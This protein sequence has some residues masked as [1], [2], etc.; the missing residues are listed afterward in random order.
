MLLLETVGRSLL[1]GRREG[2]RKNRNS[3]SS[4]AMTRHVQNDL[5]SD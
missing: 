4:S 1:D 2:A 3:K 5:Q